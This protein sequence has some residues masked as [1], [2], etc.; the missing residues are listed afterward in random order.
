MQHAS[1]VSF[2][3]GTLS[4]E[5]LAAE[6][7]DEVAA[8]RAALKATRNG[9]IIVSDGPQFLINREGAKRL[10]EAVGNGRLPFDAA[11]Y[12]ADC[13]VM[14]D[15]FEFADDATRDAIF[16]VEDDSGRFIAE[17]DDWRPTREETMAALALL[18][19]S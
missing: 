7:S 12:V 1:I 19:E 9:R 16:F 2:L 6:I 14:N 4:P 3:S 15:N 5:A 11:N 8:F 17:D 18:I 13:I 10:L